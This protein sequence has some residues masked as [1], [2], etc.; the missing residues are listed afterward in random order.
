MSQ[1]RTANTKKLHKL[2]VDKLNAQNKPARFLQFLD[3]CQCDA[4]GRGPSFIH[5]PY[6]QRTLALDLVKQ[7]NKLDKKALVQQAIRQGKSG[8]AIGKAVREAEIKQLRDYFTEQISKET[9]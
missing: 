6:A 2:L 5:R 7:L 8:I 4:Q 1:N 9:K 3:A